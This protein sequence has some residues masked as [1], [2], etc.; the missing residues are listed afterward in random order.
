MAGALS[1]TALRRSTAERGARQL[2]AGRSRGRRYAIVSHN[3]LSL[4][5]R[6]A[7]SAPQ[8]LHLTTSPHTTLAAHCTIRVYSRKGLGGREGGGDGAEGSVT[9]H[10]REE[11]K[12]HDGL[13]TLQSFSSLPRV[14]GLSRLDARS[15]THRVRLLTSGR[16]FFP[17]AFR[18]S[19]RFIHPILN[20]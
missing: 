2:R 13:G 10:R 14:P 18:A 4:K 20:E 7:L 5:Q 3:S 17:S 9:D 8:E 1:L 19:E 15:S 12:V 11:S 6:G 16:R